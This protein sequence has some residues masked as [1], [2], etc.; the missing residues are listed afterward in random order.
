[1]KTTLNIMLS[2]VLVTLIHISSV[3][4]IFHSNGGSDVP[5]ISIPSLTSTYEMPPDPTRPGYLFEGW[6]Y[7]SDASEFETFYFDSS[8]DMSQIDAAGDNITLNVFARWSEE[9]RNVVGL[10]EQVLPN[11]VFYTSVFIDLEEEAIPLA[12]ALPQTSQS[13]VGVYYVLGAM[14]MGLG[15]MLNKRLTK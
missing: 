9:E 4:I 12:D 14:L 10:P 6:Y 1:M 2:A 3:T 13:S 11:E 7:E 15:V 5:E 8:F